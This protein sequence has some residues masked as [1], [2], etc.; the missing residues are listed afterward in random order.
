MKVDYSELW[1]LLEEK[2]I[3]KKEF[4]I[5]T[6]LGSSTYTNLL[7]NDNVSTASLVKICEFLQC[8]I[9]DIIKIVITEG[10]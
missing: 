1:K 3:S 9:E 6:R 5:K 8:R 10:R 2:K 7:K 4:R